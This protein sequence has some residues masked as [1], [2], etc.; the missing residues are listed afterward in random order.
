MVR[1]ITRR[2]VVGGNQHADRRLEGPPG[3]RRPS[4]PVA[5]HQR[6]EEEDAQNGDRRGDG[7]QIDE[8]LGAG[9]ARPGR[10]ARAERQQLFA[11]RQ[12]G[13]ERRRRDADELVERHDLVACLAQRRD[14]PV[15]RRDGLAAVAA[16]VV[17]HDDVAAG[18]DEVVHHDVE[19]RVGA[20][21]QS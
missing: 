12:L 16:A 6:A 14:Q 18:R 13:V 1:P 5:R 3:R 11:L 17:E 19:D 21:T 9:G 8:D 15:Q 2:L 10:N 4:A 7:E 20:G